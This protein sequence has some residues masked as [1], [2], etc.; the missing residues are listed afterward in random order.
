MLKDSELHKQFV[1]H[2]REE[3]YW[4][5][6]FYVVALFIMGLILATLVRVINENKLTLFLESFGI[7]NGFTILAFI[8]LTRYQI[9]F[10]DCYLIASTFLRSFCFVYFAKNLKLLQPSECS[11]DSSD[12]VLVVLRYVPLYLIYA[13]IL[14]LKT[15][16][17]SVV[18]TVQ[19]YLYSSAII[20]QDEMHVLCDSQKTIKGFIG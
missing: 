20:H 13:E 7:I 11:T 6:K 2:T 8:L 17:L 10:A 15:N 19:I 5:S 18:A 4:R 16:L 14:I 9:H 12:F 3:V 1:K